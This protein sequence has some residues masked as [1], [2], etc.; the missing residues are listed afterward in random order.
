M[1]GGGLPGLPGIPGLGGSGGN[2]GGGAQSG[3]G[4][5]AETTNAS[6]DSHDTI[7]GNNAL[8]NTG[9]Y[10]TDGGATLAALSA[11]LQ[12]IDSAMSVVG[13]IAGRA[14]G[15][16]TAV[17]GAS[18]A[19]GPGGFSYNQPAAPGATGGALNKNTILVVAI[20]GAVVA[21]IFFFRKK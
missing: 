19:S 6:Q 11:N 14:I 10:V 5:K 12:A 18:V 15:A 3:I 16:S 8:Q 20:I 13:D 17:T 9:T 1:T 21:A 7:L 4:N 2:A